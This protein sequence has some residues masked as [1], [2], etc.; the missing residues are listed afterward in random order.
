MAQWQALLQLDSGL[1]RQV[2]QLY[3]RTFSRE[4]RHYACHWIEKQ[5]W[6]LATVDVNT[7][8][9]CFHAFQDYLEELWK[10][11]VLEN[12][13]LQGPNFLN[14]KDSLVN[15]FQNEPQNLAR[16]LSHCLK[17]E[18]KILAL[19]SKTQGCNNPS[20]EQ[21]STELD[22][23]VNGLKQQT[24]EV[25]REI[26]TLEDLYEQL[27]LIQKTWP[28][29]VQQ[30]NEMNQSRAAVEEDCLE[31]ESFITQ[32]KQIVLQQL[33]GILNHTSQVVAT[34]TDVELPK[35]KHRQQMA[36]IG[37]PVDTSLDHLQKWFT[38]AAEVIVG[39]REQLLKL[40]EQNNKYNC[41][42]A[43]SLAANMVEIQKFAL[44]LLTKLLT[45]ALVVEKQPVMQN[46]SQRPLILKTG[47]GF[48]AKVR[49]LA[50]HPEFKHRLRPVKPVFD[51]DVEEA[52]TVTGFRHFEFGRDD[53]KVLDV[54]PPGALI[55]EFRNMSL[56]ER[57]EKTKASCEGSACPAGAPGV[58][59]SAAAKIR[60]G[61]TEELHIIK[62]VTELEYAGLKCD[63][64]ASSLPL[65]VVSSTNQVASAWAS[66]MWCSISGSK[67]L[68]LFVDP[69]P[70][71]W[72]QLAQVLSWQFLSVGE[73][74][75]DE[76][77]LSMLR[78]KIAD[79]DGVVHWSKFSSK[80]ESPWIWID[81]ILDLIKKHLVDLWR[82]GYI[83]GFV[84]RERT[85]FLLK[86]KRPGTF[87]LRFSET[88][89]DGA[90]SFSW[91]DHTNGEPHV[92]AVRP[93]I[94]KE[95]LS[96]SLSDLIY[97]Y[98][99][100]HQ[101]E[102]KNPLLYLYPD[103]HIDTAFRRYEAPIPSVRPDGY[104]ERK[105][106][107]VSVIPTPPPSPPTEPMDTDYRQL[108]EDLFPDLLNSPGEDVLSSPPSTF[109]FGL[110]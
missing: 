12:R 83:M 21:N 70:L 73:R 11:S 32:T 55:A 19:A 22:N 48:K 49:Y 50:N 54:E 28:S 80:N 74:E 40:Q 43:S 31:R 87:V 76:D 64:E 71:I 58:P 9:S 24:L 7:A 81:G 102:T 86:P 38:V 42:D 92:H 41:T 104:V 26:K 97:H 60:L 66:I 79:P 52:K 46:F 18:K 36:C 10:R 91:V 37:S 85:E 4:I 89:K 45:N 100:T 5:D 23:K 35:W 53:K 56:K 20:M 75:L 103:I 77:Q 95:L 65:I 84:S 29:R 78:D 1:Q 61:V 30:C 34:L 27:D 51:K 108:M 8:I 13:I 105:I 33:C 3:E 67:N 17:E 94:K 47:V 72:E 44:S 57:R 68:S 90:I 106:T 15:Q 69:P 101:G 39:I 96:M 82:D 110:L 98:I 6:D 62:F 107:S 2:S 93:Y 59:A 63:I 25:K 99:L 16:I 88:N 109:T 14:M